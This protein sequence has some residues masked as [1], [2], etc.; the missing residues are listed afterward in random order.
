[1]SRLAGNIGLRLAIVGV[2]AV[3]G[4]LFRDRL[5]STPN[6]LR[7]GDCF[8]EPAAME[9]IE[10]VQHQPC[11][12]PHDAEVI[13]AAENPTP[14]GAPVLSDEEHYAYAEVNCLPAFS[15]Y[16]GLELLS[17]EVLDMGYMVPADDSWRDGDR[18][19]ICYVLRLD[20]TTMTQSVRTA[21]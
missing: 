5:S 13:F 14:K 19:V 21:H 20:G 16:T 12:E 6:D 17:Q 4:I 8:E 11:T 10:D 1:M 7:V 15:A 9:S 18:K 3:G 2:L